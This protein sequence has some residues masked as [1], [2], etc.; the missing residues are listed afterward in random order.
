MCAEAATV[1]VVDDDQAVRDS[2][3]WLIQSVGL[4]VETF[5]DALTFLDQADPSRPG[6]V[7]LDV[8]L[9]GISGLEVQEQL[10]ERGLDWP[11]IVITGHGDVPMAVRAMKSGA[12]DFIEKPF[13][14]QVL[15]DQV[16]RAIELDTRRRSERAET[17]G[18]TQRINTLTPREREVLDLVVAGKVTKQIARE[19][20]LADKTVEAHRARVM[21]KM[22]AESIAHLVRLALTARASSQ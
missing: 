13:S 15:L 4:R 18:I 1:F 2:L 12:L 17:D 9:P 7:V 22:R 21:E 5:S 6:C 16:Q 11:I 3:Q 8:R 20:N 14:D 10:A 19:L